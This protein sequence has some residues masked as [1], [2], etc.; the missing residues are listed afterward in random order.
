MKIAFASCFDA[1]KDDEQKVWDDVLAHQPD[2]LLLLGDNIY[3]DYGTSL[4]AP[5]KWSIEKFHRKMHARYAAQWAVE[6]F[7][8]LIA[9]VPVIGTTWD[10]HDFAWNNTGGRMTGKK[11]AV[12]ADKV[13]VS[14]GLHLQF[15]AHLR[16]RPP[17]DDYPS[18]PS[19]EDLFADPALG[20]NEEIETDDV[21]ILMI[22]GRTYREDKKKEKTQLGAAQRDWIA[23]RIAAW[24]G[25]TV[26][27]SGS[28]LTEGKEHWDK[29]SD[30][31]WFKEQAFAK[32]VVVS[33]DVHR[34]E[35]PTDSGGPAIHEA[36]SSGAARPG[37][38]GKV[39]KFGI[40]RTRPDR[41]DAALYGKDGVEDQATFNF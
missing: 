24:P 16:Q 1:L 15:R 2:A 14:R 36:I 31:D 30:L 19:L 3:M 7:R 35:F 26:L 4:G 28:P 40:L 21:L 22:D 34:N 11:S 25:V 27:G 12:P 39:G 5:R 18:A 6:S 8:R 17:G 33:G 9:A 10:D 41:V 38:F 13:Q 29:Y 23:S 32:T 37:L 20:I